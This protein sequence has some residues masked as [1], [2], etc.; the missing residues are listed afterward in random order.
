[1][2]SEDFKLET[3]QVRAVSRRAALRGGAMAATGLALHFGGAG[4]LLA[5]PLQTTQAA[6]SP[7]PK[8]YRYGHVLQEYYVNRVREIM[9]ARAEARAAIRTPEQ[10]MKLRDEVRRKLRACFGEWPERTP[11]NAR[12]TGTVERADYTIEKLIYESRPN[13]LVTANVYVPKRKNGPLPAVV[14]ACG[15]TTNGKAEAKYQEFSRNLARQ[16][17]VTLIYDPPS[18]GERFEYP[19]EPGEPPIQPGVQSHNVAGNQMTL[20]GRNFAFWEAWDGIRALDYLLS[21]PDVDASRVG[22]TGNSGGG[23]Q[24]AYLNALDDR[25]TMAAPNCYVTRFLYNLENEEPADIEQNVPGILAAGLDMADYFVA[26]LPRPTH[27]GGEVNDFFDVRGLRETYEEL[28]R[29][30]AIVGAERSVE[31]Y[32]GPETHGYNRGAREAMYAFFNRHA[33]VDAS[34]RE[35]QQPAEADAV[36]QVTAGGQVHQLKSK[37]TFDFT[38][39]EAGRLAARRG[40]LSGKALADELTRLLA[41]PA[42]PGAPRY[43]VM[44]E[45]VS[46]GSPPLRGYGFVIETEPGVFAMLHALPA[47]APLFYFPAGESATLYVPHRS[48]LAEMVSGQAPPVPEESTR[49]ALDVRGMGELTARTHKDQGDDF[50]HA[51]RSDYLYACEG[52][53]LNESYCGRRVHDLLSTLDLFQAQGYRQVHLVGRGMGAITATFAAVLHPLVAQVTLHN[54]L[55]S[56]HELTQRPRYDWPLSSLVFGILE[57]TDLPDALR[58]LAASKRLTVVDP[59]DGRMRPWKKERLGAHLAALGLDGLKVKWSEA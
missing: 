25:F 55:L 14:G 10:V 39:D 18:Q 2:K 3:K 43:R 50:F 38:R 48:S 58:K 47:R 34:P 40:K 13:Y 7:L 19:D 5:S 29:L 56:Y 49:F 1:M 30:Y 44:R 46:Q 24:T 6:P 23:T 16:G 33:R 53:K 59:W 41:L 57:K 4:R 32:V 54:A 52:M 12:V 36:L 37:R 42:R 8:E 28:R 21:R 45:R 31:L 9:R 22:V 26:Q 20:V 35:P 51:Y 27:L 15:H 17:Y 11:L